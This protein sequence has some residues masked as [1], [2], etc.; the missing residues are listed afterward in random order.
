MSPQLSAP[1]FLL[2]AIPIIA[3]TYVLWRR[4]DLHLSQGRRL[5]ALIIRL[6][7]LTLVVLGLAGLSLRIPQNRL[8]VIYVADLSASDVR[9]RSAMESFINQS[10]AARPAGDLNGVV[11]VGGTASVE[12]PPLAQSG[13]GQFQTQVQPDSTNLE[14][15][16][17]LAGAVIPSGYRRRVVLLSDGRQ[18]VGDAH[19]AAG[20]LS[21]RGMRVDVVPQRIRGGPDVRVDGVSL[22]Q[23]VRQGERFTL[24]VH[25]QSNEVTPAHLDF[26][27]DSALIGTRTLTLR[28]GASSVSL[29]Q[30]PLKPGF[31]SYTI[32]VSATVDTQPQNNVGSGFTIVGG[33]PRILV[34]ASHPADATDVVA[35][36]RSTG[37]SVRLEQPGNVVPTLDS[38]QHYSSVVIVDTSADELG[39]PL[40][41]QLIPYTRDLGHGLVVIGG[42]RAFGLG[43]YGNT[44]LNQILPVQMNI[45]QRK[46]LPT[47]GVALIVESLE[48]PLPVNIS[49]EAAK[50][51]LQLLGEQDKVAI[52]DAGGETPSGWV[53]SLRPA[54]NKPAIAEAIDGMTPG[55]PNSY[56][57][58]LTESANAL[59]HAGTRLKHIIILGDGD[60][61]DTGYAELAKQIRRRGITISA[62]GTNEGGPRDVHTLKTIAGN[63]G[64]R[65]YHADDVAN[66]PKIFLHE[67]QT[68]ARS[69]VVHSTF[70]PRVVASTSGL[71]SSGSLPVL[72]GY[73]AT[74]P[75][76]RAETVLISPKSDPVLATWQFGLG[77]TVAWTSDASGLWT[78]SWLRSHETEHFWSALVRSTLP[79]I[80]Q[81]LLPVT[82]SAHGVTGQ[83]TVDTPPSLGG[84]PL[85]TAH[86]GGPGGQHLDL[87]LQ[88]SSPGHYMGTFPARREGTYF[89]NVTAR[90]GGHAAAGEGGLDMAYP[91]EFA[92]SGTDTPFLLGLA[93]AGGGS[94]LTDPA[95]AWTGNVP[96][97]YDQQSL[98]FALWLIS[99]L[100]FPVDIALR[101]LVVSG[102]DLRRLRDAVLPHRSAA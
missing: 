7:I 2:L 4:A 38:L 19:L 82:T 18:N 13:F 29:S 90:G 49:K 5:A 83:V 52:N 10:S 61:Y 51:V 59:A 54:R 46:E 56:R 53:V 15:G 65:Y 48:S 32:H 36:L 31:H 8:A 14:A 98:A 37:L 84:Q 92:E 63:G 99:A 91:A 33:P 12:Q 55:D 34:I 45:P 44:P 85:V 25:L 27:R 9:D 78:R 17:E 58:F 3:F 71:L 73:V 93:R 72:T 28:S 50:G 43:G 57:P 64:G 23:S 87:T 42:Q 76:A 96:P 60:A 22:P 21:S 100:L 101:R 67:A 41:D 47:V 62:V 89:V 24:T 74:T 39:G 75:K 6:A 1:W 95:G 97:A 81:H 94:V 70:V 66:V 80:A 102:R 40:M 68:V 30:G 86:V 16:L 20:I 79:A 69:G 77:R 35:D 26:E 88:P 11:T